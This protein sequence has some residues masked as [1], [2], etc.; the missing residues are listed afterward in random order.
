[1]ISKVLLG[2]LIRRA[3]TKQGMTLDNLAEFNGLSSAA[4]SRI[5]RGQCDATFSSLEKISEGLN[6]SLSCL[7][8]MYDSLVDT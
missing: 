7:M 1:M 2:H 5:E 4:I 8:E 3:R 6:M